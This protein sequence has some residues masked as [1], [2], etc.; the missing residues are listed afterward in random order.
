MTQVVLLLRGINV[1]RAKRIGMADLRELLTEAGYVDVRTH[2]QSG[3]VVLDT[4]RAPQTVARDVE[5][6]LAA[7]YGFDVD[8]VARTGAELADVVAA[9][10]LG[11]VATD[12]SKYMVAFLS[13]EPDAATIADVEAGDYGAER[14][15]A[16]G[17]E[18][19]LWCP[20]GII[21]SAAAKALTARRLGVTVTVR[22]WNTVTKVLA[23]AAPPD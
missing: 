20:A 3:N 4:R 19:Y 5:R 11:E 9:D 17:R 8:V 2:L 10:P 12:G 13:A 16:R 6:R 1:G 7:R 21:K 22:N 15:V 18:I 23:L 14:L